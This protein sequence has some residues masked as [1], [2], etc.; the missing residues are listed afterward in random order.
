MEEN[1]SGFFKGEECRMI[2]KLSTADELQLLPEPLNPGDLAEVFGRLVPGDGQWLYRWVPESTAS[3]NGG[4]VFGTNPK[5]RWHLCHNGTVD[6]SC[7]GVFDPTTPADA[8]LDA[9]V[10]DETVTTVRI[11]SDVNF[12]RRHVITRSHLTLDFGGHRVTAVGIEPAK[13]NDP[14]GGLLHFTG[15]VIGSAVSFSFTETM[16]EGYDIFEVPNAA[17][18]PID[19]WWQVTVNHLE[20]RQ[21]IELDKLLCVTEHIDQTHVRFNYKLGWPLH[22][23]RHINY[24]S[25][26]PVCD[27]TVCNMHFWGNQDGENTGAQPVAF[28]YAVRC[29]AFHLHAH[30]T[31]WPVIL[32][33]HNTTYITQQ[34]SLTNPIEVVVGGTGY[35]T[36]QIHCLY[37][38]VRDC[39]TSNARHLNDFTGSAYCLV[40]NCHGDGDFHGAFVTHGQFEH[41]LTYLGNSG[42][43]SF[44]NSGPTWG[45][46]AKRISVLRHSGCWALG[47]AKVSDLTLQDVA[48]DKTEKYPECG[49]FLLNADGLQMRGCTGEKLVLT[50]H[51][52]RSQRPVVVE[53]CFFKD[54]IEITK[55]GEGAL[56]PDTPL[57]LRN[58]TTISGKESV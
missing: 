41:D 20:G 40:E 26:A 49:T 11:N 4:T 34:C 24:H 5:G 22:A 17:Q 27:I 33:R 50:Q 43:L 1:T 8:A 58:N 53:D 7:F 2:Y 14:F 36:Q 56:C 12:I 32:R 42:L 57:F 15:S 55:T 39:T 44:A 30:H 51:S 29:N 3:P 10:N 23:G 54:G 45:S 47:F 37:G 38:A 52:H 46:S 9:L 13:H 25:I 35:L 28:E 48:I 6:V 19:S 16:P 18:F 21:E 31:Y